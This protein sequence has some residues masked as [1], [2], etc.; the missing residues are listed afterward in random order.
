MN[1]FKFYET[2]ALFSIFSDPTRLKIIFILLDGAK[3]V[4]SICQILDI[5]QS[6]CSHQLKILKQ[7]EIVKSKRKGQH[8]FISY[9]LNMQDISIK[10]SDISITVSNKYFY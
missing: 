9:W 8:I 5:K 10:Y 2:A 3:N 6:T 4:K 7:S 1:N